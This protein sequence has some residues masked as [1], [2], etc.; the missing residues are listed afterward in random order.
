M[1]LEEQHHEGKNWREKKKVSGMDLG[2]G[3]AVVGFLKEN[4]LCMSESSSKPCD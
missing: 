3:G 1:G 4:M 2:A